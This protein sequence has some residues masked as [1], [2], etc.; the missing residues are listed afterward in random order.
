MRRVALLL[1]V[2]LGVTVVA[3]CSGNGTSD[4][5]KNSN[6]HAG[7]DMSSGDMGSMND[8]SG[9]MG[10]PAAPG[11]REIPVRAKSLA[12]DPDTITI[13]AGED[14]TIVLNAV[15]VEHDFYVDGIGAIAHAKKAESAKGGL[16]IAKPGTYEFWCSVSGHKD[17]G[18]TGRLTV[19]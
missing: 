15:D 19:T 2:L 13:K 6:D 14:V 1:V 10:R 9:A 17:G 16:K 5:A 8:D 12:F 11:A 18:M 3:A 7:M 4:T